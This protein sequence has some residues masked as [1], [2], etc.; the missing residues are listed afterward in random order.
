MTKPTKRKKPRV[1]KAWALQD[2]R[3]AI[4]ESEAGFPTLLREKV[5]GA[6]LARSFNEVP[7]KGYR[8]PWRVV[9]VEIKVIE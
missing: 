1:Y 3:G 5:I 8:R 7:T 9:R 6:D 4:W 2:A